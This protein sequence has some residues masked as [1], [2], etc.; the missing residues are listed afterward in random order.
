MG[1]SRRGHRDA[2]AAAGKDH[3]VPSIDDL[4]PVDQFHA[5]GKPLT[6]RLAISPALCR[7]LLGR[8]VSES[9]QLRHGDGGHE[10]SGV[11]AA[12]GR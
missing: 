1:A 11:P 6:E 4:A 10:W 2:L 3:E 7:R 12:D 5:G 9:G 8:P